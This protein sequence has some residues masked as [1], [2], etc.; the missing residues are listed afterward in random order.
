MTS[1]TPPESVTRT[2]L[3]SNSDLT[4]FGQ[5]QVDALYRHVNARN[6]LGNRALDRLGEEGG[7]DRAMRR[8]RT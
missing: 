7:G 2:F 5:A 3:S 1:G 8:P 6:L 4:A